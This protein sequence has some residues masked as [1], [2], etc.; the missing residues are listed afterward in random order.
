MTPQHKS[1]N[2]NY[3]IASLSD[4]AALVSFGNAIDPSLNDR[5]LWLHGLLLEHP[6]EGFIESVPA[7]AP[8]R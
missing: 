4:R 5:V 3:S 8:S 2:T 6:P 1:P 7:Y